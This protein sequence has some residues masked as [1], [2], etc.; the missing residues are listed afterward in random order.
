MLRGDYFR[1]KELE[2]LKKVHSSYPSLRVRCLEGDCHLSIVQ[3]ILQ[4][5]AV[6]IDIYCINLFRRVA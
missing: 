4:E 5:N 6:G 3:S 2:L 1:I